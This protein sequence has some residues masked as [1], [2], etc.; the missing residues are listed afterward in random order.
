[1]SR[2]EKLIAQYCPEGVEYKGLGELGEFYGGLIGK[3][4]EDFKDGNAHFITYMNVFNNPALDITTD[5]KVRIKDG[6]K[7]N[8]V[9]YGDILFTGSSES[10]EEAG[11]TSVLTTK[12]DKKLYLNSFCFGYRFYEQVLIPDFCK[13]LFRSDA[14]RKQIVKTASGVTRFNVSKKKML[15]VRIPVPP[16]EVQREIV[17]VLDHFTLLSAELSAEL[18]KRKEQYEEL[19]HNLL[20]EKN[21]SEKLYLRDICTIAKGK[22]AIQKANP[23]DYPLVVTTTERKSSDSFQFDAAAVCIP[24]VSSRGH[25]VASLNHV[26]YQEGK[27][28]LGNILCAVIPSI[29]DK[30]NAKYLYH[31]LECTK[32]YTLVPLM[33]GGANVSMHIPDIERVRIPLPPVNEQED[34]VYKLD[35][36]YEYCFNVLPA[37]IELRQ[38]QYEYYRDKLMSFKDK[39]GV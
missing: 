16:L 3:S 6:E 12:T 29:P 18:S 1:M 31:Y 26:Y 7:Q 25:G 2:I 5:D 8:E 21:C 13:H 9:L 30:I 34:I 11:F 10:R 33:K 17:R 24:L 15:N 4:K 35:M 27:F 36:L 20:V 23:G 39:S 28:A 32:D 37:E 22:T 19:S 14:L 38:K